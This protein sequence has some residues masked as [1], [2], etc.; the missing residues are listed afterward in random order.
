MIGIIAAMEKEVT[1]LLELMK[2]YKEKKIYHITFYQGT[3][4]KTEIVICVSGIGKVSLPLH[5]A[6]PDRPGFRLFA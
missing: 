2:E 5:W 3:I 1:H 6:Q 4:G